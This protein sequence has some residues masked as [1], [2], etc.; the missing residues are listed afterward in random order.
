MQKLDHDS[1]RYDVP[2]A[3]L[4]KFTDAALKAK[5]KKRFVTGQATD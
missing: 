4:T 1:N 3:K 2:P 5:L